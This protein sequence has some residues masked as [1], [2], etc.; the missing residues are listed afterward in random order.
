MN[1]LTSFCGLERFEWLDLGPAIVLVFALVLAYR[2]ANTFADYIPQLTAR[3]ISR[4]KRVSGSNK[5]EADDEPG[6]RDILQ[7]LGLVFLFIVL[8]P[9]AIELR[10]DRGAFSYLMVFLIY[11]LFG[12][13]G[14]AGW[15]TSSL[16]GRLRSENWREQI[17]QALVGG[18]FLMMLATAIQHRDLYRHYRDAIPEVDPCVV[19]PEP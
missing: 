10:G 6:V 1:W 13:L 15:I 2:S 14:L 17:F 19:A 18:M 11:G 8:I 12:A 7:L 5:D 16:M 3:L 9:T 4:L